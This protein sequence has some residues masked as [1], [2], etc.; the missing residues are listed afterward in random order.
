MPGAESV[1]N[2]PN[3]ALASRLRSQ[4]SYLSEL[5]ERLSHL[6]EN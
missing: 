3:R 4:N 1:K 5:R 6:A 2:V